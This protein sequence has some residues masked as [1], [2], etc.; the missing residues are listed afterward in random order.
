MDNLGQ[1]RMYKFHQKLKALKEKIHMWNK[2][3]FV[4]IFVDKKIIIKDIDLIHQ[5]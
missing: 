3:H 5:K 4:N 1:T 2:E